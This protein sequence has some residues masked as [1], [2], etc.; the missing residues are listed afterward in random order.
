MQDAV[1]VDVEAHLDLGDPARRRRDAVEMEAADG[2]VVSCH[3]PLALEHVDLD[4]RLAVGGG[5]EHL[6]LLGRNRGVAL[7]QRGHHTAQG[8][9]AEGKRRDVEQHDVAHVPGEHRTLD[10]RADRHDLVGVHAAVRLLAEDRLHQL[11]HLRHASRAAHQHHL[12]HLGGR[13]AGVLERLQHRTAAALDQVVDHLLELGPGEADVE[14]L[15]AVLIGGDERQVDVGLERSGQLALGLLR[16]LLE[17]LERHGVLA[18]VDPLLAL[19]LLR[20]VVDDALVEIVAA[21]VRVP[22]RRAHLEHA[23]ADLEDRD[24]EGAAAQIEDRD[25]L[26]LLLVESV[27][28]RGRG[29]LV[30]DAL[31]VQPGDPPGILGRLA[32]AVVEVR[33]HGNDR[34]GHLLPEVVLSGLLHL[35]QDHCRNLGWREL[36]RADLHARVASGATHDLVGHQLHLALDL[37]VLAAHEALDRVHGVRRIGHRLT[38]RHEADQPLPALGERDHGGRGAEPLRVGDNFGLPALHHRNA[39]IG[40]TEIDSDHLAHELTR[41]PMKGSHACRAPAAR[42]G[43][44]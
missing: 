44:T 30:D 43:P 36:L 6:A 9:D 19:E 32:L 20:Q 2:L 42:R 26:V 22:V 16:R 41:F 35:L 5:G 10:G 31:D 25:L 1:G 37:F 40:G 28:E 12:I 11:L 27:G 4:R 33:R 24:V 8:L 18:Q 13:E 7:D 38:P 14:V 3:G 34:L 23:V 29:G 15:G 21:E 17:A 39:G